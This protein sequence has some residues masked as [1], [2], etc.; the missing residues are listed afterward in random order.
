[1][2]W[3]TDFANNGDVVINLSNLSSIERKD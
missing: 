2:T 1:L 3:A